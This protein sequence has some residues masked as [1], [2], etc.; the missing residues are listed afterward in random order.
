MLNKI[1]NYKSGKK[2]M[3]Q[4]AALA[5]AFW[6]FASVT[7]AQTTENMATATAAA[8]TDQKMT[9]TKT[10]PSLSPVLTDYKEIKIGTTAEE[11][12]D[13]LGK[14]KVGNE[15]GFYYQISDE[16]FA[17]IRIDKDKNVNFLS[18]TY[19]DGNKNAPKYTDVFGADAVEASK[20]DGSIYNLIDYPQ[21]GYWVAYSR[22]AGDKPSVSVTMQKMRTVK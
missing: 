18:V 3:T 1:R 11:V 21:A 4:I 6:V 12:R 10:A 19:T 5:L 8:E 2:L 9:E 20:P 16:E 7:N 15:N 17:Q 22:T 13:K 14:P